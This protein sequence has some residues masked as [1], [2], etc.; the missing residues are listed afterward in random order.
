MA[1]PLP[2]GD[3][4]PYPPSAH[5]LPIYIP[6]KPWRPKPAPNYHPLDKGDELPDDWFIHRKFGK[7][8]VNDT[9]D[10]PPARDDLILWDDEHSAFLDSNLNLGDGC[11]PELSNTIRSIIKDHWDAFDPAGVRRPAL[12]VK[13]DIDTGDAQPVCVRQPHYGFHERKIMKD[14]LDALIHNGMVEPNNG[15]WAAGLVLAPKPHQEDV[16]DITQFVWRMC[17]NYRHLNRVTKPYRFPIPRCHESIQDFGDSHGAIYTIALD[18]FSGFHQIACTDNAKDKLAFWGPDEQKWTYTVMPFGPTNGPPVYQGFMTML[19]GHWTR[20]TL[21]ALER[22]HQA[23][24][25][26]RSKLVIDDVLLLS[27]N[28]DILIILF[29]QVA[30]TFVAYRLSF[31]LKK[32]DFLKSRVEWLGVDISVKGNM[33][34]QSKFQLI[35]DWPTPET[36]Q[37]L[38]SFVSLCGFYS[39]FCPWFE[40]DIIPLRRL[41]S[42]Y[43]HKQIPHMA[44]TPNLLRL[45]RKLKTDLT[46]SPLLARADSTMPFFLKTDWSAVGMAWILMQPDDSPSSHAALSTL[47]SGGACTFDTTLSGPRLRPIRF[48]SR[49][50][51]PK[52]RHLHSLVGEAAA[53][54]LGISKNRHYL[55]GAHFYWLCDCSAVKALVEYSG[56]NYM[57]MRWAQEL[58]GYNFSVIHRPERMM[59]D[60][61]ALTRF[62]DPLVRSHVQRAAEYRSETFDA[63]PSQ[64]VPVPLDTLP[65]SCR[66][67]ALADSGPP[68]PS[69]PDL[70]SSDLAQASL[71]HASVPAPSEPPSLCPATR[72]T[73][74]TLL[75]SHGRRREEAA[76]AS[77]TGSLRLSHHPV[78]FEP[79]PCPAAPAPAWP[80]DTLCPAT[81]QAVLDLAF[82]LW[83]SVNSLLGGTVTALPGKAPHSFLLLETDA[84]H[85]P[86]LQH[87]HPSCRVAHFPEPYHPLSFHG[88]LRPNDRVFG[89]DSTCRSDSNPDRLLWLQQQLECISFLQ[90]QHSLCRFLLLLPAWRSSDSPCP[91][92]TLHH[93]R[94]LL[95]SRLVPLSD[96]HLAI[97]ITTSTSLGD[98]ILQYTLTI[99]GLHRASAGTAYQSLSD[100]LSRPPAPI[101][102]ISPPHHFGPW[103]DQSLNTDHHSLDLRDFHLTPATP[104]DPS[105]HLPHPYKTVSRQPPSRP[106]VSILHPSGP[107]EIVFSSSPLPI[108][109]TVIF[110]FTANEYVFPP[111]SGSCLTLYRAATNGELLCMLGYSPFASACIE[112]LSPTD[113]T[114]CVQHCVSHC[115]LQALLAPLASMPLPLPDPDCTTSTALTLASPCL[116]ATTALPSLA[117]WT[118]SY[119]ADPDTAA[120]LAK[121][122][123]PAV[124][125]CNPTWTKH[126]LNALPS[127]YRPLLRD[128]L[129]RYQDQRLIASRPIEGGTRSLLLIIVP[130]QLRSLIFCAY[131]SSPCA[132]HLGSSITLSRLRLR[133]FWPHMRSFVEQAVKSCPECILSKS[134]HRVSGDLLFGTVEDEPMQLLHIDAYMA[135]ESVSFRG[136][137]GLLIILDD[138]TGFSIVID[139]DTAN[140]STFARLF[141]SRVLLIHG[142]CRAV[143]VDADS[144]FRGLFASMCDAL[145]LPLIPLSRGNHQGMRAE[146]F[147]RY[148]NQ[149]LTI[150]CSKR[151]TT[152]VFVEAAQVAAYAWNSAPI[153]GTD[154]V[155]SYIV[156]G[157]VFRFPVD[158]HLAALPAPCDDAALSV[159]RYLT[160]SDGNS[161]LS[162][163]ILA[164]LNDD[165]RTAHRERINASRTEITF[166]VGDIVTARVQTQSNSSKGTVGKLTYKARGPF[167][168][169][170][171]LGHGSYRV[172]PYKD[173]DAPLLQYKGSCL[174]PL[175]PSIRPCHPLD[176]L[177]YRFLNQDRTPVLHPLRNA[178]GIDSYNHLWLGGDPPH[179]PSS[180]DRQP[181]VVNATN[182]HF[183]A[184]EQ[185]DAD[186]HNPS[187]SSTPDASDSAA[188]S[189][190]S[191]ARNTPPPTATTTAS[192][193][194]QR[195]PEQ[196]FRA[197]AASRDRLFLVRYIADG[198][199]NPLLHVVQVSLENSAASSET[200][201]Y[202][203]DGR[204][205]C[206]FL[207]QYSKDKHLPLDHS[208][209][210][211]LWHEYTRTPDGAI[212]YGARREFAA[213]RVP[214]FHRFIAYADFLPL[215]DNE[216][217]IFGPF[218]FEDPGLTLRGNSRGRERISPRTWASA[219]PSIQLSDV[220]R[221][222]L[223][224]DDPTAQAPA[225][226]RSRTS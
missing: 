80:D 196:L 149:V 175:P 164:I 168:V 125:P 208:R 47:T 63:N 148:L 157:R 48:G 183:P 25:F 118:A 133:F 65:L 64:F 61:D 219:L 110:P 81:L 49:R 161:Q 74:H 200:S 109:N 122:Q 123:S 210:R 215:C 69:P 20:A 107:A 113:Q 142:I 181:W 75:A 104:A 102:D 5:A 206:E 171:V 189:E 162:R 7:S 132:G 100:T 26:F 141:V 51:T 21:A 78:R 22:L 128:N 108:Y 127:Q 129:V 120:I 195:D 2:S 9:F 222:S 17:V 33:P 83:V 93:L 23:S 57:L 71:A 60:V 221:P 62:Y 10:E 144:K 170:E 138:M 117:D 39:S 202:R 43:K 92:V 40:V 24:A 72:H 11:T 126:E 77:T 191:A 13:F 32:C 106:L 87:L 41:L 31:K 37:G 156:C 193:K 197:T 190:P 58:L 188:P 28:T 119:A 86:L 103:L 165:R 178:L 84:H 85:L 27:N 218:D 50:C 67:P 88:P 15:P 143:V 134:V 211:T 19:K 166:Q 180:P 12:G 194:L 97:H 73:C 179:N 187:L 34:A 68:E 131:H 151:D 124:T 160:N 140:S 30:K 172:Q 184:V 223:A 91:L 174:F 45:F 199:L 82:P 217:Y 6:P 89:Y 226:K 173:S 114:F 207:A 204:Y 146:R 66:A 52:E 139:Y 169:V 130:H 150:E 90:H 209:W 54:R 79:T 56:T 135:G 198:T 177:D 159:Q 29:R 136:S 182:P 153:D 115:T 225:R 44:W 94:L 121:L 4:P 95:P 76:V 8:L 3:G 137:T 16:T 220:P 14:Q 59:R 163:R 205:Y 105:N 224:L 185:L 18:A 116:V 154:L 46:S 213:Q 99:Q 158:I 212:E 155:R 176:T 55:W 70:A 53:G 112:L 145:S 192:S 186:L 35:T 36:A 152:A 201:K 147:N 96:W 111:P 167:R 1:R 216:C 214:D 42:Q 101:D 38:H 98:P 203:T